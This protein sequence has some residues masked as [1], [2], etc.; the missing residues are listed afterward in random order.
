MSLGLD[1]DLEWDFQ[2][3]DPLK[4]GIVTTQIIIYTQDGVH[5]NNP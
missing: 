1:P 5:E 4:S 3:S 2:D